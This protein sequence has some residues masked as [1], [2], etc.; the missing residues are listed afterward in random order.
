MSLASS[1]FFVEVFYCM[2]VILFGSILL[3][4]VGF[5]VFRR[6][7]SHSELFAIGSMIVLTAGPWLLQWNLRFLSFQTDP[8][9]WP[10]AAFANAVLS[11]FVLAILGKKPVSR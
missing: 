4:A 2:G 8:E 3:Q 10:G 5:R 9:L 7:H 6:L 11:V 1:F